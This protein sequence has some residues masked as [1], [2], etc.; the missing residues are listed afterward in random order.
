MGIYLCFE[1]SPIGQTC[2]RVQK[3]KLLHVREPFSHLGVGGVVAEYLDGAWNGGFHYTANVRAMHGMGTNDGIHPIDSNDLSNREKLKALRACP[4]FDP[5]I[6][7]GALALFMRHN[8]IPAPWTIYA[9]VRKLPPAHLLH[10]SGG[11]WE[12]RRYR[13]RRHPDASAFQGRLR[14]TTDQE[15]RRRHGCALCHDP[16]V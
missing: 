16:Y 6:D 1:E 8:Y 4:G 3:G 10:R 11:R 7:R 15:P 13:C 14:P 2:Q 12:R 5:S 9:G